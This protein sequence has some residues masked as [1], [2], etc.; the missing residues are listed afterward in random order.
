[1]TQKWVKLKKQFTDRDHNNTYINTPEF[2]KLTSENFDARLKEANLATKADI[3]DF[4]AKTDVDDKL[5]NLNKK[6]T[7]NKTTN[8]SNE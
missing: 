4:V 6:L 5:K 1:M 7:S 8:W 3:D 2:N